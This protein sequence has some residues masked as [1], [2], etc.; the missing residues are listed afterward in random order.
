M[1]LTWPVLVFDLKRPYINAL[2]D[3]IISQR[4]FGIFVQRTQSTT[5]IISPAKCLRIFHENVRPMQVQS[6]DVFL[7]LALEV[8]LM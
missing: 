7:G 5:F 1:A 4:V 6:A 8:L 3:F 2:L